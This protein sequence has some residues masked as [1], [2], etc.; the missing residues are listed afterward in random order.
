MKFIQTA[1]VLSLLVRILT[2]CSSFAAVPTDSV[3]P[4][5]TNISELTSTQTATLVPQYTRTAKPSVV[6]DTQAGKQFI[7]HKYGF[8][9]ILP[10]DSQS[11]VYN[12]AEYFPEILRAALPEISLDDGGD[13]VPNFHVGVEDQT[14][15]CHPW[16]T[17]SDGN[18]VKMEQVTL[19]GISFNKVY[20]PD[21]DEYEMQA[22]EYMTYGTD[23][24]VHFFI[25]LTTFYFDRV[26]AQPANMLPYVQ[27]EL[28]SIFS[29]LQWVRK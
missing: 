1:I 5:S 23:V 29:T 17:N 12:R 13:I 20:T 3:V 26:D 10:F 18:L 21:L 19:G 22:I 8:S 28:D 14:D 2:S 16:L 11:V 27:D 4:I 24:C 15:S 25:S 6:I 7:S 9:I